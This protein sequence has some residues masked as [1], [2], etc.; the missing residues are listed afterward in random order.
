[1][2]SKWLT[3]LKKDEREEFKQ[4]IILAEPVISRLSDIIN[5]K[6]AESARENLKKTNYDSPSWAM[7]QADHIG[8]TRA[9]NELLPYLNLEK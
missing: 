3:H 6:L 4:R 7:M 5:D 1:M 2:I 9:L 8:Y